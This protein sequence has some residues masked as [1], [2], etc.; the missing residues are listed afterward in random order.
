MLLLRLENLMVSYT[1]CF[2]KYNKL[3]P[4]LHRNQ[5]QVSISHIITHNISYKEC[6]EF[7]ISV[8]LKNIFMLKLCASFP[9][10]AYL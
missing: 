7:G 3:L 5:V 4:K 6:S 9:V 2:Y 1:H 10:N 8:A